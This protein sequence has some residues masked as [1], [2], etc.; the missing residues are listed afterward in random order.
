MST[1]VVPETSIISKGEADLCCFGH[2]ALNSL[3]L[4][5]PCT[6]THKKQHPLGYFLKKLQEFISFCDDGPWCLCEHL[7]VQKHILSLEDHCEEVLKQCA[8]WFSLT[9]RTLTLSFNSMNYPAQMEG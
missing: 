5:N 2:V 9:A 6:H 8:V 1:V 4:L 7:D 3:C